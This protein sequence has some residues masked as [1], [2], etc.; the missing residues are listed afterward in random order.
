MKLE[1]EMASVYVGC[2][3]TKDSQPEKEF[4]E[5]VNKSMTVKKS[6]V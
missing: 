6:L 5:T 1:G 3:I 4:W 2:G